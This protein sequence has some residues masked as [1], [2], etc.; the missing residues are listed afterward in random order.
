MAHLRENRVSLLLSSCTIIA[1]RGGEQ[2]LRAITSELRLQ[3]RPVGKWSAENMGP[4]LEKVPDQIPNSDPRMSDRI[5]FGTD[6]YCNFSIYVIF[7]YSFI[8]FWKNM[9]QFMNSSF[10]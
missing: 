1:E 4:P 7:I 9:L 8:S 5:G 6:A 10:L 3:L 2:Q